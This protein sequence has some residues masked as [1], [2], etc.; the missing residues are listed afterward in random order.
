MGFLRDIVADAKLRPSMHQATDDGNAITYNKIH[1]PAEITN[2]AGSSPGSITDTDLSDVHD[3]NELSISA[4]EMSLPGS[5]NEDVQPLTGFTPHPATQHS[6]Q[7]TD[8]QTNNAQGINGPLV[9]SGT[10]EDHSPMVAEAGLDPL[11]E[12]PIDPTIDPLI[13]PPIDPPIETDPGVSSVNDLT[14]LQS[15][16]K[17]NSK[18]NDVAVNNA[19]LQIESN[20]LDTKAPKH[21]PVEPDQSDLATSHVELSE[22]RQSDTLDTPSVDDVLPDTGLSHDVDLNK[23]QQYSGPQQQSTIDPAKDLKLNSMPSTERDGEDVNKY[24]STRQVKRLNPQAAVS[25]TDVDSED[26]HTVGTDVSPQSITQTD[27]DN[28]MAAQL[29]ASRDQNLTGSSLQVDD[30]EAHRRSNSNRSN[31]EPEEAKLFSEITNANSD[32]DPGL[33]NLS[34]TRTED[35]SVLSPAVSG[36]SIAAK[37]VPNTPSVSDVEA[38]PTIIQDTNTLAAKDGANLFKTISNK[39]SNH[40]PKDRIDTLQMDSS[41]PLQKNKVRTD[42]VSVASQAETQAN[43]INSPHPSAATFGKPVYTSDKTNSS[44]IRTDGNPMLVQ[45]I[46]RSLLADLETS[47][48]ETTAAKSAA[49]VT[50]PEKSNNLPNTARAYLNNVLQRNASAPI[51]P[52]E[53][54]LPGLKQAKQIKADAARSQNRAV[55]QQASVLPSLKVSG[56]H[57]EIKQAQQFLIGH[58]LRIP[59]LDKT[60][61]GPTPV[62]PAPS[63]FEPPKL[64]IGQIDIVVEE[65]E[66]KDAPSRSVNTTSQDFASSHYLRRL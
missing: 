51:A 6:E 16:K 8:N 14:E 25:L 53:P 47:R 58:G 29:P 44:R 32:T 34:R 1:S 2:Q 21:N 62:K 43:N 20:Q 52:I 45:R 60:S 65:A 36:Q 57:E 55:S 22:P 26:K 35:A 46:Y 33:S 37:N 49:K 38:T 24:N 3:E 59:S 39:T 7:L 12:P 11:I 10:N 40:I 42:E 17:L 18:N 5:N 61:A 28:S 50:G 56:A 31:A 30:E 64:E 63:H 15:I 48:N 9:S 41:I 13:V 66:V 23:Q 54:G 19:Q 4:A 27:V